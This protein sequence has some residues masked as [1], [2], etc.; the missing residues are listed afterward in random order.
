MTFA[1]RREEVMALLERRVPPPVF[2]TW[3]RG[4]ELREIGENAI[5]VPAPNP[6]YKDILERELRR[7]LEETFEQ[8]FGRVPEI[9]FQVVDGL[10]IPEPEPGP[11]PARPAPAPEPPRAPDAPA[12][13][14]A[15]TFETFVT[16]PSNRMA[17]SA[18]VAVAEKPGGAYNPLFIHGGVGLGKTHL[19]HAIAHEVL[20]RNPQARVIYVSCEQFVNDYISAIEK[21][22]VEPFR[23]RYRSADLLI[24]DDVHFLQGKTSSQ[25]EFFHTFNSL[26][27]HGRQMVLSSDSPPKDIK[28]LKDHLA[29]RFASGLAL[30]VDPPTYEMR[31]AI[32]HRIAQQMQK[33]LPEEVTAFIAGAIQSNVRELTGAVHRVIAIASLSHQ[34]LTLATAQ[35]ALQADLAARPTVVDIGTIQETVAR[36]YGAKVSDLTAKTWRKS[37]SLM[38]QV[39]IY[40]CKELTRHSLEEIGQHFG[41]RDHTTVIYAIKRIKTLLAGRPQLRKDLDTLTR[42]LRGQ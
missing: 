33:E 26:H 23:A 10:E 15:Y 31:V 38:R 27:L 11:A 12:L 19:L 34:P 22:R 5:E 3:C 13:N 7:P 28:T 37:T 16:G 20:R 18:A 6:F 17:C 1:G 41:R 35:E 40:L 9:V 29:S 8:L 30:P 32:I 14:R 25:E 21:K 2:R 4:L 24:V 42:Q 36:Y 39:C